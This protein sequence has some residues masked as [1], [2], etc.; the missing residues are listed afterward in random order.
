[1]SA[2]DDDYAAAGFARR[3][4]WGTHPAV[5]LVDAALAY[6]SPGSPLYLSAGQ[7]A[8]GAM[9]ALAEAA[10]AAALPVVW[11]RVHYADESC[12]EAPLFAAKVPALKVFA[13]G[14][15]LGE[16][17]P[18]LSPLPGELVV[19]KHYAS[20]F[21]GTSLAAWLASHGVDTLVIG[22][23]S[24]SGCVRA[25]ALDAL[26]HGFRPMV[27]REACADRDAGPHEHNLFDLNAKYADVVGLD[28][29]LPALQR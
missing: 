22:G 13:A 21:A 11:T 12:G 16:F 1:M 4:G 26:Q 18:P 14:N 9:E 2:L 19:V 25:S 20:A 28:E 6:T 29:A 15:P 27:V 24:T 3:L 5:L 10:R 23:Y 8:A 7:A 17:A